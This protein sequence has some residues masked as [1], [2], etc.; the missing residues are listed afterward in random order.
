MYG[1]VKLRIMWT[2]HFN[3]IK[4]LNGT[5]KS[6]ISAMMA[7]KFFSRPLCLVGMGQGKKRR[8]T[9]ER[10]LFARPSIEQHCGEYCHRIG[11]SYS[12]A[13]LQ[14]CITMQ[15]NP[16]R[17]E[18]YWFTSN[19]RW[20]WEMVRKWNI[21]LREVLFVECPSRCEIRRKRASDQVWQPDMGPIS[22]I[23]APR[24]ELGGWCSQLGSTLLFS[25]LTNPTTNR[26]IKEKVSHI[27]KKA[28]RK[29]RLKFAVS[30]KCSWFFKVFGLLILCVSFE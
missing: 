12:C 10:K 13:I 30:Y 7:K 9:G 1:S 28:L 4:T 6:D 23:S 2:V 14:S 29:Q 16:K 3:T 22:G 11:L 25:R 8:T 21:L 26:P 17:C 24:T 15:S 20:W 27:G 5:I 18:L 19:Y